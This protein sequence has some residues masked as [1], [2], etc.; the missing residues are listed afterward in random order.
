MV[1]I[2]INLIIYICCKNLNFLWN[3]GFLIILT[4]LL[5]ILTGMVLGLHYTSEINCAYYSVMHIIREVYFGW[6]FR[7]THSNIVSFIFIFILLHIGRALY[8]GSYLYIPHAWISGIFLFIILMGTAFMGYVLPWGQMSY[9]GCTVITNL[10]SCIPCLVPWVCGGFFISNP[11]L[12]RFFILHFILPFIIYIIIFI[13]IFYLH[14]VS[15]NNALGYNINNNI[16]FFPFFMSKDLFNFFLF[17]SI[18]ILE[19]LF[20]F[21]SLSHP[22]NAL[23]VNVLVTP[24]HIVPEWYFL[25]FYMILKA[26]PNKNAGFMIMFSSIFYIFIPS[27]PNGLNIISLTFMGHISILFTFLIIVYF[28]WI[29]A[30]LPQEQ[31]IIYYN[32]TYIFLIIAIIVLNIIIIRLLLFNIFNW[33][34]SFYYWYFVV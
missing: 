17:G 33:I 21:I 3:Q 8:Y 30:Q 27:E 7:Y 34:Y 19:M 12:S 1:Y 24:L 31:F 22:D 5:Q 4:M 11:S 15:S 20:G 6:F 23:E 28:L 32:Y 13:H 14:Q 18:T 26:I 29:G 16:S 25:E 9:W 2:Y 10:L